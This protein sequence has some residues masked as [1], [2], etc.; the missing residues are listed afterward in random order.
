MGNLI[1]DDDGEPLSYLKSRVKLKQH[2][3]INFILTEIQSSCHKALAVAPSRIAIR[4]LDGDHTAHFS[5]QLPLVLAHTEN[6]I[7]DISKKADK[8]I[9]QQIA[10]LSFGMSVLCQTNLPL[11]RLFLPWNVGN[12]NPSNIYIYAPK[13]ETKSVRNLLK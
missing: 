10:N 13:G 1:V 6:P 2:F 8:A 11:S 9:V 7:C 5:L 3:L 12:E 4:L